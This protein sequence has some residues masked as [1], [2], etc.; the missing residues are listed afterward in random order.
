MTRSVRVKQH[1]HADTHKCTKAV[2][3]AHN[4]ARSEKHSWKDTQTAS[5]AER[6]QRNTQ[7][8]AATHV[9]TEIV[10]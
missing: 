2:K 5:A 9:Q 7:G 6:T 10:V 4:N 8:H 3:D 1:T